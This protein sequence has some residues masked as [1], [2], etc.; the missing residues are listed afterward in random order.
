MTIGSALDFLAEQ[1]H[2][3]ADSIQFF[4]DGIVVTNRHQKISSLTGNIVVNI[5]EE[6][7]PARGG[8]RVSFVY[9]GRSYPLDITFDTPFSDVK[10]LLAQQMGV[11]VERIMIYF[12]RSECD[13]DMNIEDVE[14]ATQLPVFLKP[15]P[16]PGPA[17]R[18]PATAA[19]PVPTSRAPPTTARPAPT[20]GG[21]ENMYSVMLSTS[22]IPRVRKFR[23]GPDATGKDILDT[24]IK[25]WELQKI[26]LELAV[27]DLDEETSTLVPLETKL[28]GLDLSY[29]RTLAVC[30][31]GTADPAPVAISRRNST[32]RRDSRRPSVYLSGAPKPEAPAPGEA[33]YSF[34]VQQKVTTLVIAFGPTAT[35]KDAKPKVAERLRLPG[36]D[37][38]TLFFAG[39]ALK[40]TF[41]LSR[42]R[43]GKQS[44]TVYVRE[45]AELMLITARAM[46]E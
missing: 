43:L 35:V 16:C 15:A 38:V 9:E 24:A 41:V 39:K 17:L 23:L 2:K 46:R 11:P 3:P 45:T 4:V 8:C 10:P 14:Y 7:P 21:V 6:T 18:A 36:P 1:E 12:G 30:T 27:T 42:L 29:P 31:A 32:I 19:P 25:Y 28:G 22:V 37:Y 5:P 44:I 40:E 13:D 33:E 26:D 34:L 20:A